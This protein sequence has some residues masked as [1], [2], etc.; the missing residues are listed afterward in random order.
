M[1]TS[2]RKRDRAGFTLIELL[3]VIAII[4]VLVSLLLP[5]VQS[6][7]EAARRAQ[8]T[9]NLKQI[10]IALHNY[11]S[12]VGCFPPGRMYPD[13]TV[14]ATGRQDAS[15]YSSYGGTVTPGVWNGH[16]SVHCHL[17]NYMEQV[18]AYNALNFGVTNLGRITTGG[19]TTP[20]SP[21]YT[22]YVLAQS[23]F[24]CPSDDP[25][26]R[27]GVAENSYRANFGGS[28]ASAGGYLRA[29][30]PYNERYTGAGAPNGA[31][32][33]GPGLTVARFRDG[34]SNTVFFAERL[35]GSGLT[36]GGTKAD[37]I[38][39]SSGAFSASSPNIPVDPGVVGSLFDTCKSRVP[40]ATDFF[41]GNGRWPQGSDY[42]DGWGFSWYISTLYNHVATPN[43]QGW[44]CGV[45]TSLSDVPFDHGIVSARSYHPGGVN[46]LLG[47]GSVKFIKDS[48]AL[49][50]WR[51]LGTRAGGEAISADQY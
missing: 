18:P 36:S 12:A 49:P 35:K 48:V 33:Y 17:L 21:N 26:P 34:T 19:G 41:T 15:A 22:S 37:H 40:L 24:T 31:F 45:G 2:T 23:T 1:I 43:W 4:G 6:A 3:V 7:R 29:T 47:D 46:V 32:D 38:Y 13:Q 39:L 27:D 51:A 11:N 5:A 10:G 8:C 14:P 9:N 44:D 30:S 28:T 20:L 25:G 42:C 16:F 50:T